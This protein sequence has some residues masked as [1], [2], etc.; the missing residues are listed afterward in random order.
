MRGPCSCSCPAPAPAPLPAPPLPSPAQGA[1][2]LGRGTG[3]GPE[4]LGR[5][6]FAHDCSGNRRWRW[7]CRWRWR[8]RWRC[9]WP[10]D[11]PGDAPAETQHRRVVRCRVGDV[12]GRRV[13]AAEPAAGPWDGGSR[14]SNGLTPVELSLAARSLLP[15]RV[16]RCWGAPGRRCQPPRGPVLPVLHCLTCQLQLGKL[17]LLTAASAC[18]LRLPRGRAPRHH[19]GGSRGRRRARGPHSP[20]RQGLS[21]H[22]P[23]A[24]V[25]Q[26][27]RAA[28]A[29]AAMP[30]PRAR[31]EVATP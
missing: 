22:L 1:V 25:P 24:R 19:R 27:L 30:K 7:R 21:Q 17:L 2:V 14:F 8:W 5:V 23:C 10:G 26:W 13:L 29:A 11:G 9:R 15:R 16:Q 20:V 18:F 3:T 4:A 6:R 12:W 31:R 28:T